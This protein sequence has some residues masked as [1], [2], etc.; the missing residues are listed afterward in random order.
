MGR[1]QFLVSF[2]NTLNGKRHVPSQG[3]ML[4]FIAIHSISHVDL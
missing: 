2:P 1:V 4:Q 3:L